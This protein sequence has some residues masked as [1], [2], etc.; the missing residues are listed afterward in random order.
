MQGTEVRK[1]R[2]Q[3]GLRA[4]PIKERLGSFESP[5]IGASENVQSPGRVGCSDKFLGYSLRF[6]PVLTRME[7]R[8]GGISIEGGP[9]LL[10]L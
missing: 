2:G 1:S 5:I 4:G 8:R 7:P 6:R 3:N 10:K 9:T